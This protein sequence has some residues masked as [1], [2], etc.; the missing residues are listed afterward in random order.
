[1]FFKTALI[2]AALL[3]TVLGIILAEAVIR[4]RAYVKKLLLALVG[5]YAGSSL[6]ALLFSLLN[7]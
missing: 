2:F 3:V 5:V 1:M 7:V 6:T 4:D